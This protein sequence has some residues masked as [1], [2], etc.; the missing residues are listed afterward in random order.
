MANSRSARCLDVFC[1]NSNIQTRSKHLNFVFPTFIS[2]AQKFL[3]CGSPRQI[4][5]FD[6]RSSKSKL[7]RKATY[8]ISNH[9]YLS[10][11]VFSVISTK[12][13]YLQTTCTTFFMKNTTFTTNTLLN[14]LPYSIL[15]SIILHHS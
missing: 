13:Y 14:F 5:C 12:Q 7:T 2:N 11:C 10:V 9:S 1:H 15:R 4:L 3:F 8:Y 6:L